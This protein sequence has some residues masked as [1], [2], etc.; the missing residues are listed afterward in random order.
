MQLVL[1]GFFKKLVIAD[2][3]KIA[4]DTIFIYSY[5]FEGLSVLIGMI[6]FSFQIYCDF[7]GGIDIARGISEIMGVDLTENF[8]RPFFSK[9]IDEYWRRWHITLG[10]WMRDYVF[11][12]LSLSRLFTKS[13]RFF[14]KIFGTTI[15]KMVPT[16]IATIITFIVVGLWHGPYWKYVAFGLYYGILISLSKL[17]SPYLD[18]LLINYKVKTNCFSWQLINILFVFTATTIGR[19]F[20]RADG[21]RHALFMLKRTLSTFNPWILYDGTLM[22]IGLHRGDYYVL[23][24]SISILIIAE[25]MQERGIYLR[26]K[27]AEQ[28]LVFRW[29]VYLVGIFSV[30]IFGVYGLEYDAT[31][32][33]YRGF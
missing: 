10:S 30:L 29:T 27:L 24:V 6:F 19:Y 15:G 33:I 16:L 12:P 3:L 9:S 18:K 1:W 7:S 22:K 26:G 4:V 28:N 17:L 21:F 23:I 32:F 11:Y 14:R 31:D 8:K 13:G 5:E 25:I 2:R 20:V